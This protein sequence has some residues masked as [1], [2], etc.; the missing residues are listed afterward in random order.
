MLTKLSMNT[1]GTKQL[2][3]LAIMAAVGLVS[4]QN[5]VDQPENK[6]NKTYCNLIPE[7]K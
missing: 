4:T 3:R 6:K 1:L 7:S 2:P 5:E